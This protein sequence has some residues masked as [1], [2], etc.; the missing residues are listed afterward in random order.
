MLGNF[1]G[2]HGRVE[3]GI[4]LAFRGL[5]LS[6]ENPAVLST[7]EQLYRLNNE[8]ERADAIGRRALA[9]DPEDADAHLA[10]GLRLLE[11]QRGRA[12]ETASHPR[13]ANR[14]FLEA[15]RLEPAD[16]EN[17]RIIA[18]ERVRTHP[19]FR[20]GLFLPIRRD[21]LIVTLS[22]PLFWWLLSLLLP[23]LRF[24]AWISLAIIVVGY[25]YRGLFTV[26]RKKVL[27][28]LRRGQL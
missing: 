7:L 10:A 13:D 16:G 23:I 4:T 25:L 18:H 14:H 26:C 12:A 11:A 1:L 6:A 19:F 17:L 27:H 8:P 22:A 28:D 3:D 21:L 24:L 9:A 5:S 15:L 2:R 20:H